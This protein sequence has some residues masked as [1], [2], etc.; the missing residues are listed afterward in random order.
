MILNDINK[1]RKKALLEGGTVHEP[2]E[3]KFHEMHPRVY[4]GKSGKGCLKAA[5]DGQ[6][7]HI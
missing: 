7:R 4:L 1:G 3:D 5:D 2:G 6:G